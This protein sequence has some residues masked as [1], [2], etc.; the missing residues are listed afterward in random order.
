VPREPLLYASLYLKQHR[1]Q[2]YAELN[3]VRESGD[4]ARWLEFFATAIRVSC[5]RSDHDR[6]ENLRRL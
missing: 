4:F 5:R 1:Q 2:Y 6:T 3:S